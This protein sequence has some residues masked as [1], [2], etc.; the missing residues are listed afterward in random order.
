[1]L[2]FLFPPLHT[3]RAYP[4][5]ASP[6]ALYVNTAAGELSK[7]NAMR[8]LKTLGFTA[9]ILLGIAGLVVDIGYG[10]FLAFDKTKTTDTYYIN[11]QAPVDLQDC[12]DLT[13]EQVNELEDRKLFDVNVYS[14]VE[15]KK[16]NEKTGIVLEE[17]KMNYFTDQTLKTSSI[18][19]TGMQYVSDY[20]GKQGIYTSN[21]AYNVS[22]KTA[23]DHMVD[24][25][26]KSLNY[27]AEASGSK[28]FETETD[29]DN[30]VSTDFNYY[31][32]VNFGVTW[33]AVGL[34][35]QLNR[36]TE[37]IVKI[38]DGAYKIRLDGK[39]DTRY[40]NRGQWWE[41]WKWFETY[42]GTV[43]YYN[44]DM[45]F[46]DI[47]H[48]V[49]TNNM[50]TGTHYGVVDLS[51]YFTVTQK[52]NYETEK[53]E[54][55]SDADQQ[56]TYAVVKFN[57]H[58][59]GAVSNKQ[60]LFGIIAD[61]SRFTS[62]TVTYDTD[63]GQSNVVLELTTA[64]LTKRYSAAYDGYF[65]SLPIDMQRRLKAMPPYKINLTI[66]L[67]E[68]INGR[69]LIGF[70]V[71]AF[72]GFA[73]EKLTIKGDQ[74]FYLLNNSLRNTNLATIDIADTVTIV[75]VDSGVNL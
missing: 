51:K 4:G 55:A 33:N 68:K 23:V 18:I 37:Y 32:S 43:E 74:T 34:Q 59:K 72:D 62:D 54:P 47:M 22:G 61:D 70:D 24:A 42:G 9:L 5:R 13:D 64:S 27:V 21:G 11:D 29:A 39:L 14:N 19:S 20:D 3:K 8:V 38:A 7:S 49:M 65:L 1:M 58:T 56:V 73:M 60:S 41:F 67:T 31:Q 12:E 48:G 17:L 28:T 6:S 57:Y 50:E 25:L 40:D 53:W 10:F 63:Y 46:E 26:N 52:Y 36:K 44:W 75:N 35:T 15:T 45:V 30:Y 69:Q 71:N 16:N 66:D 2:F